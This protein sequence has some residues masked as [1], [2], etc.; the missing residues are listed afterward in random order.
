MGQSERV[1]PEGWDSKQTMRTGRTRGELS[2]ASLGRS[3]GP[4]KSGKVGGN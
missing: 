4:A 1:C 2:G 3:T